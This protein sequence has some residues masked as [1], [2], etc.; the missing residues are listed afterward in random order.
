MGELPSA[1]AAVGASSSGTASSPTSSLSSSTAKAKKPKKKTKEELLAEE[2][3]QKMALVQRDLQSIDPELEAIYQRHDDVPTPKPMVK[4]SSNASSS[5]GSGKDYNDL[6]SSTNDKTSKLPNVKGENLEDEKK[7]KLAILRLNLRSIDPDLEHKME[8]QTTTQDLLIQQQKLNQKVKDVE[9]N[10]TQFEQ[11]NSRL[12]ELRKTQ[13]FWK[14]VVTT[15]S[16]LRAAP[17]SKGI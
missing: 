17:L 5:A 10:P 14:K 12:E 8:C 15:P 7:R 1:T 2:M 11:N 6:T 16:K 3:E 9:E 4:L 13:P